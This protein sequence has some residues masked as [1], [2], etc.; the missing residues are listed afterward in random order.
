VFTSIAIVSQPGLEVDEIREQLRNPVR[1]K[2][3]EF[4]SLDEVN[5]GLKQFPFDVL[6]MRVKVFTPQHVQMIARVRSAFPHAGLITMSPEIDPGAKY[7]TK[8]IQRHKLLH[9]ALELNDLQLIV[10]KLA[11]G[12]T[13]A[14]RLHPRV[15]REGECELVDAEK[16]TRWKAR[17]LDFAQMGA[18][19]LVNPK[20]PLKKNMRLQLHY[21][22]TSEPTRIH[23]IESS[24]V[25]AEINSGMV[26]TIVN[27]PQQVIGMRFIAAL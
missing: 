18:R 2:V 16:G 11:K 6:L 13:S 14:A 20:T 22:S 3:R 12:E 4:F 24:I 19:L 9:E 27:G 15:R 26:G 17:F 7:Q 23:R 5:Q 1:F 8:S 21:R 10:E 25:W